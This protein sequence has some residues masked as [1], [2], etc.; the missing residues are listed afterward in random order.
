MVTAKNNQDFRKALRKALFLE[1]READLFEQIPDEI[2]NGIF[3]HNF[4]GNLKMAER[5]LFNR[6]SEVDSIDRVRLENEK[7]NI[8]NLALAADRITNCL[9]NGEEV[10]FVT[11]NDNDGS[12]AQ[13]ILIEFLKT[14]PAHMQ[15]LVHIE[16]AQPI[17][18]AR[19]LTVDIIEKATADRR[20]SS[21][22]RF[23]IVT[24]DNGINN[25]TE[26]EKIKATFPNASLIVTDHHL[27]DPKKVI[28]ED[29]NTIIFNPK[30]KPTEYFKS[31]NISGANTL[32]VLLSS[33]TQNVVNEL[34]VGKP[35]TDGN[36][37]IDPAQRQ[38]LS[39]IKEIGAWANLLD[40]ANAHMADMPTRPYIIEQAVGLRPLLNVSTSMSN[41]IT[42]SFSDA[43]VDKVLEVAPGLDRAWL[44]EKLADVATLNVYARKL[45]GLHARLGNSSH[46][47]SEGE[48]YQELSQ[49]MADTQ[50]NYT[51]INPNYIEQMRP[52]IF[53]LSAIDNKDAFSSQILKRMIH[54]FEDLRRQE[55]ELLAGLREVNLLR[56]DRRANSTILYPVDGAVT[57]LFNRRLL[58]KSYNQDNNGFIL[59]LSSFGGTEAS[60]SMRS[61]YNITDILEGK[62]KIERQLGV[63]LEFQG[64]EMAA[65]FFVR[66]KTSDVVTEDKLA[67]LNIWINDRIT[68]LKIE[69]SINQ[70]PNM[71]VDFASSSLINKINK[72]VK[73]N[74][75]GMWGMPS[76]IRFS[77]NK[78]NQVFVTDPDTTLQVNLSDVVKKKKYGYQAIAT[79]F[80]GGAFVVPVELLRSV[81]DSKFKKGLRLAYMDDGVFM[82][83]QV[84]DVE[85]LPRLID[86][87]GGRQD[88]EELAAYYEDT[89]KDSNFLPLNRDD[90]RNL[91]Y[92][93]FN[94]YGES[95]FL[96]LEGL[97]IQFLD[98]TNRD[99]LAVVDTEGTGLGKAP[100]CFNIGGTNI[101]IDPDSGTTVDVDTFED[102]YFRSADG[103]E[104]LLTAEQKSSLM[105]LE[106][107]DD[108]EDIVG[109]HVVLY[110]ASLQQGL[111]V[112]ERFAFPGA[113]KNLELVSNLREREAE[114]IYN[115]RITG[116]AFSYLINNKD[117]AITKEFEDLTGIG[118][119]M[120]E[121]LGRSADVVD[122]ELTAHYKSLKN[123]DGD[124][125]QIIFQAHNMPYDKGVMSANF[126]N[127]HALVSE[128]V[129]SDTAKLARKEKLAY[130]DTPVCSFD[131]I[132]GLPA[133][134]YFYDSPFSDYSMTTFLARCAQGKGGVFAD[135]TSKLL[136]RYRAE[137][138][139]FAIISRTD[140]METELSVSLDDLLKAKTQEQ[141]P[142]NAVKY[143][144]ER[145]SSRAMIRNIILLN[146]PESKKVDLLP[147]EKPFR[148]ALEFFQD[149][150]HFDAT[151]EINIQNFTTSLFQNQEA[152]ELLST[153]NL[154][155]LT[156]R[157]LFANRE[158]QAKFH[159]GWIYEKVL[160]NYEP[161]AK[162][163]RVPADIVEQVNYY[164][165]LP[166]KKI[167][168]VFDDVIAFKRHFG[169][170]H[171]LVHEQHNNVRQRSADGQG[172]SDTAYESVLPQ[173]LAMMKLYNPYFKSTRYAVHRLIEDN[174]KGSLFQHM[175]GDHFNN[176]LARDSYSMTQMLG[177]KR[178]GKTSVVR[179]AQN[180]A[181]GKDQPEDGTLN[182]VK[183][184]L[185][186]DILP[187]HSA[188][189]GVP[190]R[191]LSQAEIKEMGKVL[192]FLV[193]NEQLKT[194]V[195]DAKNLNHDHAERLLL[196][197][198]ANNDEAIIKRDRLLE[199]FESIEFSRRDELV[200]KT[201]EMMSDLFHGEY[202]GLP[203]KFRPSEDMIDM[204]EA[205]GKEMEKLYYKMGVEPDMTVIDD[206]IE[207]LREA[208]AEREKEDKIKL[209]KEQA[210]AE[211]EAMG[212]GRRRKAA[213]EEPENE[214]HVEENPVCSPTFL[215]SLDIKRV[216]PMKFVLDKFG[217][218][219]F[220]P[221]LRKQ[222]EDM[223]RDQELTA[224]EQRVLNVVSKPRRRGP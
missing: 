108:A 207:S 134:A 42:S 12:L 224:D 98:E 199:V 49:E 186:T 206:F 191:H 33:V 51:S 114:V 97:L 48:F 58:G 215:P 129:T 203:R 90:F 45:L 109:D 211:K 86:L 30:Y 205:I 121:K 4:N 190:K 14:I 122:R 192:E 28:L 41:L 87:K 124:K 62:E 10:L 59:T 74:L 36:Y 89:Y 26:Q 131:D 46:A 18:A 175:V 157:F 111:D 149:N 15:R 2:L 222:M 78:N 165:D 107:D 43:D 184:K 104:Y 70:L 85:A 187:P 160:A 120:V 148:A 84:V 8:H 52:I 31:K 202:T 151:P 173:L 152:E 210:K 135:T 196:M 112:T 194:A 220:F 60:G 217:L 101:T 117:F 56:E 185:R 38:A 145:L 201:A 115:R 100:K 68:T 93:R 1:E 156:L 50:F 17:G 197:A 81:V 37:K 163:K 13:A 198:E 161:D 204:A 16:Y 47:F 25:R 64:H 75:A 182:E 174:V 128:H 39:N 193:V 95:E 125:A 105:T 103:K 147:E 177:F 216:E 221:M 155:D 35:G 208:K 162:N 77:P 214:L 138:E 57:K 73:S 40:Y 7:Q 116:F 130:D 179:E 158:T 22:R 123:V 126:Q 143:S 140:N 209:E 218:Q 9:L 55:R 168:Q 61:L 223:A 180:M 6:Y 3:R 188:L 164:T 67:K 195:R 54:A 23:T 29:D 167:R 178:R 119:W 212:G 153:V 154:G 136:L 144:V 127:F 169:V 99:V 200:K 94:R 91:P 27:P 19:G 102:H 189:Y 113:A 5:I 96:K 24:A 34:H 21:D 172:L 110:K 32:G 171:A 118:N 133:K 141:L 44:N 66:S 142:N 132:E 11:D 72:A 63:E 166:S 69:D 88:Q 53:N 219:L 71:E 159:D 76:I 65:G 183:F 213:P 139:T 106:A 79:D 83:S 137:N 150:Y 20:W 82:A 170:H 80:H 176:E 181:S 146:K 92:F